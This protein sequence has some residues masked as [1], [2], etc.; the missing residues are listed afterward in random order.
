[1]IDTIVATGDD[2]RL[3]QYYDGFRIAW[4]LRNGDPGASWMMNVERQHISALP[5]AAW[6]RE[7]VARADP[8]RPSWVALI[9]P[10]GDGWSLPATVAQHVPQDDVEPSGAWLDG[11]PLRDGWKPLLPC[12]ATDISRGAMQGLEVVADGQTIHLAATDGY[13]LALHRPASVAGAPTNYRSVWP[14]AA[15]RWLDKWRNWQWQPTANGFAAR[16]ACWTLS[17]VALD[18]NFPDYR[19]YVEEFTPASICTVRADL[20]CSAIKRT[21]AA[22]R[23]RRV[24]VTWTGGEMIL[25][26]SSGAADDG[27]HNSTSLP[28]TTSGVEATTLLDADLLVGMLEKLGKAP[29]TLRWIASTQPMTIRTA[30]WM[31]LIMPCRQ[32]EP[33]QVHR[34]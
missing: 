13:R 17:A 19:A 6:T 26:S 30:D 20:L 12:I 4:H 18:G 7:L 31:H 15:C 24:L 25:L 10:N 1:M 21:R 8:Q 11:E 9:H 22:K 14:S 32:S 3:Y 29:V 16:G 23:P 27:T 34:G 28:A 33:K 5:A 2:V